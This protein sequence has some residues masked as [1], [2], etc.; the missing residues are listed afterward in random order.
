MYD[1]SVGQIYLYALPAVV[2]CCVFL[3]ISLISVARTGKK[4]STNRLFAIICFLGALINAT[5]VLVALVKSDALALTIDRSVYLAF[6]FSPAFFVHF[7]HSCL[8]LE[9]FRMVAA[10]YLSCLAIFPFT[11]SNLFI[12]GHRLYSFGR[13]ADPGWVYYVF[14]AVAV[15]SVSYCLVL[16]LRGVFKAADN[17]QKNRMKYLFIG[18]GMGAFLI[19]LNALPVMGI[20]VYP[21]GNFSFIPA[22][23][24]AFGLLKYDLLDLRVAVGR[25]FFYL[26]LTVTLAIIYVIILSLLNVVIVSYG[27]A[28]PLLVSLVLAFLV[29]LLYEPLKKII[30]RFV[31]AWYYRGR[32]HYRSMLEEVSGTLTSLLRLSEVGKYLVDSIYKN[33]KIVTVFIVVFDHD[34]GV[35]ILKE[36]R[37]SLENGPDMDRV[38]AEPY[39]EMYFDHFSRPLSAGS[40]K[41]SELPDQGKIILEDV[42]KRAGIV[43]AFSI[44][45][46]GPLRGVMLLGE[47]KSGDLYT[48]EDMALLS[49]LSN[50]AAMAIANADS[51]ERLQR[52]NRDL[53]ARVRERTADLTRVIEEKNRTQAQ[54]IQSESLAAIGQL[55]AGTAHELNNPLAGALSLIESSVE[56]LGDRDDPQGSLAEILDDLD[57][58]ARE[59]KRAGRI[60]KS[61]LSLSRQNDDSSEPV[62]MQVVVEDALRI[63]KSR[64]KH[65]DVEIATEFDPLLP[66]VEGNYAQLGQAFINIINNAIQALP[67]T[68]GAVLLKSCRAEN[69]QEFYVQCKDNGCG[70]DAERLKRVF[71]P[72]FTTKPVGEGTGLGLYIAHEIIRRH[73][74]L[75]RIESEEGSGTVVTVTFPHKGEDSEPSFNS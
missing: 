62:N 1:A 53:E 54:L 14:V 49:T 75:I 55:V 41:A 26:F 17:I 50:Q 40:V 21:L 15:I 47:K 63:L 18:C 46:T 29:V 65:M 68:G 70:I 25:G 27:E 42:L 3:A 71:N 48:P 7:T 9:R 72:F 32:Y 39:L 73:E 10:A 51:Y 16:M 52:V 60:T 11:Q 36:V 2:G 69:G 28:N 4:G 44:P 56:V 37:G 64:Y 19:L 33:L 59:L 35:E 20:P 6:V 74:G 38:A 34:R 58:S 8:G 43:H 23:V 30:I 22:V 5:I 13:I 12:S 61:L 66:I 45:F 57:F 31:D 67:E 24:L